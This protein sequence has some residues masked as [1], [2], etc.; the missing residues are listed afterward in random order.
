VK[1]KRDKSSEQDG[2]RGIVARLL[3]WT[4]RSAG[5]LR[6]LV[7]LP[8]RRGKRRPTRPLAHARRE[9]KRRRKELV[10][11]ALGRR[12]RAA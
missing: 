3:K 11:Q 1:P 10:R 7:R 12:R 8:A 2:L 5:F 6:E 4:A 9:E